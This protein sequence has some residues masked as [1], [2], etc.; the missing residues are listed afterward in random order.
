VIYLSGLRL[1]ADKVIQ[2]S[3]IHLRNICV[4]ITMRA[5][6]ELQVIG[7]RKFEKI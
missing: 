6:N 5:K 1:V 4:N 7:M 3:C 2:S